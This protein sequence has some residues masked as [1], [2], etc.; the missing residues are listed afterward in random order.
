MF[1]KNCGSKVPEGSKFC[2][3]CGAKVEPEPAVRENPG[4][5]FQD[6]QSAVRQRQPEGHGNARICRQCGAAVPAGMKFCTR[7]GTRMEAGVQPGPQTAAGGNV[8]PAAG[9]VKP[10]KKKSKKGLV[11]GLVSA[12]VVVGAGVGVF[13]AVNSNAFKSRF[14][15]PEDYYRDVE[16]AWLK[17]QSEKVGGSYGKAMDVTEDMGI[18]ST[19]KVRVEEAGQALLGA[20]GIDEE[21]LALNDLEIR[22]NMGKGGDLFGMDGALYSADERLAGLN[23]I[24]DSDTGEMYLQIPELSDTYLYMSAETMY[25]YGYIDYSQM[26]MAEALEQ[27]TD[28]LPSED[29]VTSFMER[30]GGIFIEHAK[31]VEKE[32]STLEVGDVS[33]DCT[34]L[35]VT[36]D[37]TEIQDLALDMLETL[38][39]DKDMEDMISA[40]AKASA[41]SM[42]ADAYGDEAAYY[43]EFQD[44]LQE[45]IDQ[46][47]DS[48]LSE[49]TI[50]MYVWV[51]NKGEIVGRKLS[52]TMEGETQDLLTFQCPREGDAYAVRILLGDEENSDGEY[53]AIEGDG[54]ISG[55]KADGDLTLFVGEEEILRVDIAGYDTKK[56]DDGYLSG[57][58][59]FSTTVEEELQN[60]ALQIDLEQ[61][62][63]TGSAVL[64]ILSNDAA[65]ASLDITTAMTDSYDVS[66]PDSADLCDMSDYDEM[67]AYEENADVEGLLEKL[68]QNEFFALMLQEA[69]GYYY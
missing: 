61:G 59:T 11:I 1:C 39:D 58:F 55:D 35:T 8:R 54:T 43:E 63:D 36:L 67:E 19:I 38:R 2:M 60:Y 50:R 18:E 42:G 56:A 69:V 17:E 24:Y 20:A 28:I 53:L 23:T 34:L 45:T 68:S 64:T 57:S 30:Y 40:V 26:S 31:D 48:E 51:N 52:M 4:P 37:E 27:M 21:I 62:E 49:C 66:V 22:M 47:E 9:P 6:E 14:S 41:A 46:L 65:L 7:C 5:E 32:S 44:A 16:T 33:Q 15:S 25:E 12:V 10:V 3:T 13:A 29:T